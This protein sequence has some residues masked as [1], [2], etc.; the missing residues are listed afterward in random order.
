MFIINYNFGSTGRAR[1]NR[2]RQRLRDSHRLR[3]KGKQRKG[4]RRGWVGGS[5]G[6]GAIGAAVFAGGAAGR[7]VIILLPAGRARSAISDG[8]LINIE[9]RV[10]AAPPGV[11]RRDRGSG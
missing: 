3:R 10:L 8:R 11:G 2:H 5:R 6:G 9:G 7:R 4:R 1:E